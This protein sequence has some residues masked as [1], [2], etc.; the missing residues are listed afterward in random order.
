MRAV[1]TAAKETINEQVPKVV[2]RQYSMQ[3]SLASWNNS[4]TKYCLHYLFTKQF[5]LSFQE[6]ILCANSVKIDNGG[7]KCLKR[8]NILLLT[9]DGN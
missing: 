7:Q 1:R 5:R 4:Y 3:Y 2:H 6:M 9:E 8:F